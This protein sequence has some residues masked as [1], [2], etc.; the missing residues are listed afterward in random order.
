MPTYDYKCQNCD[1]R[2]ESFQSIKADPLLKCPQCGKP[3]L[4]RIIGTGAGMIFKGNGFYITDYK[5][6]GNGSGFNSGGASSASSDT[7][8]SG[9][10]KKD[11]DS[12]SK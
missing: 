6:N 11:Q 10:K 5:R 8:E 9:A 3:E 2:F 7:K 1:Y 12:S 4:K